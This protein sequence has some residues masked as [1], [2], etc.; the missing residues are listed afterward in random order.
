M[1]ID[2]LEAR[3]A[4][5]DHYYEH[6][7][8]HKVFLRGQADRAELI[9]YLRKIPAK[10]MFNFLVKHVPPERYHIWIDDLMK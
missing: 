9:V 4:A 8:D 2:E 6:S 1:T 10:T 7:D 3:L 5:H